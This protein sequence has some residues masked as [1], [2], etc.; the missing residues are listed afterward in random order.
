MRIA[1]IQ[2]G[3]KATDLNLD[4]RA[5]IF[6]GE[7]TDK[8]GSSDLPF[9]ADISSSQLCSRVNTADVGS[10]Q[11]KA[12]LARSSFVCIGLLDNWARVL[13]HARQ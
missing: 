8:S 1:V 6:G 9:L 13:V 5:T 2:K 7:K 12:C 3:K 11:V 10:E 4:V